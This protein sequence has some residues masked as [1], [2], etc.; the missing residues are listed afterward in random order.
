[1]D[2]VQA[3]Y[4][5]FKR[6][7]A[8]VYLHLSAQVLIDAITFWILPSSLKTAPYNVPPDQQFS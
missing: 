1:M 5:V 6:L 2:E 4:L 8:A 7:V 3:D